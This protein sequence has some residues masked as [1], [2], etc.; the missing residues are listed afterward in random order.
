M[1]S[2]ICRSRLLRGIGDD[3]AGVRFKMSIFIA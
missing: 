2:M 3:C 1:M